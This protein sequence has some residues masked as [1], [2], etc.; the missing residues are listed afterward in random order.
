MAV[1]TSAS[2]PASNTSYSRG[3]GLIL[4]NTL[5]VVHPV[6]SQGSFSPLDQHEFNI[7]DNGKSALIIIY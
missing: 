4:D 1:T 3:L 2:S 7:V 6:K 5:K